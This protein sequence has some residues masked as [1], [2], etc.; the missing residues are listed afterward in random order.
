MIGARPAVAV[1]AEHFRHASSS[2]RCFTLRAGT[3]ALLVD[4]ACGRP[5]FCSH[6]Q[7]PPV[8]SLCLVQAAPTGDRFH[9]LYLFSALVLDQ[10]ADEDEAPVTA[11]GPLQTGVVGVEGVVVIVGVYS[12]GVHSGF[13]S[14]WAGL[15]GVAAPAGPLLYPTLLYYH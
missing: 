15:R 1:P 14:L 5:A 6:G 13:L 2:I 9:D 12:G 3:K 7:L 8:A 4:R 11:V 10:V